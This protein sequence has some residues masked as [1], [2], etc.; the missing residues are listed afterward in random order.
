MSVFIAHLTLIAPDT[1]P[2]MLYVS[3]EPVRPLPANDPAAPNRIYEPVMTEP[4]N[5]RR[6]I[7]GDVTRGGGERGYGVMKLSNASGELSAYREHSFSRVEIFRYEPGANFSAEQ[8]VFCGVITAVNW[9]H[10]ARTTAQVTL[11]IR[12]DLAVLETPVVKDRYLGTASGGSVLEGE[13]ELSDRPRPL[14]LGDISTGHVPGVLV[15]PGQ[16]IWQINAGA[17]LS[18]DAVFDR[19]DDAGYTN[20]GNL[21]EA[22]FL[23]ATPSAADYVTHLDRGL[24]KLGGNPV[25]RVGFSVTETASATPRAD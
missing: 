5:V 19:A 2:V 6:E 18:I 17:I 10:P 15:S 16:Q 24:I 12:D 11:T 13:E 23:A 4:A 21:S 22:A 14:T 9:M 3:D 1:S 20:A 7:F 8:K 25:G